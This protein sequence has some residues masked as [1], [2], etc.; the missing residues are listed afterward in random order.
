M[1]IIGEGLAAILTIINIIGTISITLLIKWLDIDEG[2]VIIIIN[3]TPQ[4]FCIVLLIDFC[5]EEC[6]KTV[7]KAKCEGGREQSGDLVGLLIALI[8]FAIIL[9]ISLIV[10]AFFYIFTK[11]MGKHIS[12]F[13]S[14]VFPK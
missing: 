7:K 4:I 2:I 11:L 12:R 10:F 3:I 14:L 13:C 8:L 9:I 1:K 5:I 6:C